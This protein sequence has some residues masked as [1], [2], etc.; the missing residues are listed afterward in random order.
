MQ[1][2]PGKKKEKNRLQNNVILIINGLSKGG[3]V[4]AE[5]LAQQGADIAIVDS[6]QDPALGQQIKHDVNANG[7]RCLILTPKKLVAEKRFF[8]Q[9]IIQKV[10]DTLGRLDAFISYSAPDST[11]SN[12]TASH[13][14][15]RSQKFSF[16]DSKGVA[17]AAL[18]H[19]MS[20]KHN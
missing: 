16:F 3:R 1:F 20:P 15:G 14:N 9:N 17:R 19:I 10:V 5:M 12:K 7:R 18:A 4:L 11:E 13:P 8:S 2:G 6:R